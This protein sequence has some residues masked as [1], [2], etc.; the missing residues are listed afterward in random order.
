MGSWATLP[1]DGGA[2][3]RASQALQGNY[4][5]ESS[6]RVSPQ[7]YLLVRFLPPSEEGER[8][9]TYPLYLTSSRCP[10]PVRQQVRSRKKTLRACFENIP[11][12]LAAGRG[13]WLRCSSVADFCEYAPSSR[14]QSLSRAI[15]KTRS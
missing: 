8:M 11:V 2:S 9:A 3:V 5:P 4:D 1:A 14:S 7:P 15:F 13:G 12:G 10:F 6:P